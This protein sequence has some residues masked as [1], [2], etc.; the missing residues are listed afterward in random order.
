[1]T[2]G[3]LQDFGTSAYPADRAQPA[4][5]D[6]RPDASGTRR[7]TTAAARGEALPMPGE[8]EPVPAPR[9]RAGGPRAPRACRDR[10]LPADLRT[11]PAAQEAPVPHPHRVRPGATGISPPA[12]SGDRRN[13]RGR[14]RARPGEVR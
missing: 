10:G 5:A 2:R 12:R 1:M 14:G 4:P 13:L 3:Q 7:G 8:A 6:A 11:A 9:L